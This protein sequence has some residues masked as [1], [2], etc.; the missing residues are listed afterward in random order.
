LKSNTNKT[1]AEEHRN[2]N[3][4]GTNNLELATLFTKCVA[5]KINFL[6]N[7][8]ESYSTKT[9]RLCLVAEKTWEK[10]GNSNFGC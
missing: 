9:V 2:N 4:K 1:V 6:R 7:Q 3:S 10:E 8:A 5:Q